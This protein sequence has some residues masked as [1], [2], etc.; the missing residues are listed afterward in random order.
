MAKGVSSKSHSQSQ[1]N[2]YANQKNPNSFEFRSNAN[3]HSNQL[4]PNNNNYQTTD[5][6][7]K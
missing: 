5:S 1:I 2:N 6:G 3:N 7:K 4:N